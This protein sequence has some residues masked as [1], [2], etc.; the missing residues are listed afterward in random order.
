M[1]RDELLRTATDVIDQVAAGSGFE[2]GIV[3]AGSSAF[4][5]VSPP[6]DRIAEVWS[7]LWTASD[8]TGLWPVVL[9]QEAFVFLEDAVGGSPVPPADDVDPSSI[10]SRYDHSWDLA[11]PERPADPDAGWTVDDVDFGDLDDPAIGLFAVTE[12]WRIATILGIEDGGRFTNPEHAAVLRYFETTYDACLFATNSAITKLAL[13]EPLDD[14]DVALRAARER[15]CY[16]D[17]TSGAGF[18]YDPDDVAAANLVDT[19]WSF[20]WD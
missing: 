20:W 13:P 12:G 6:S 2:V 14:P 9:G 16:G 19:V 3:D 15:L 4:A 10:L 11:R 5:V 18:E 8:D 17:T 7:S 1:D